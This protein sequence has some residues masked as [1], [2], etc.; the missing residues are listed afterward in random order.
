MNI[1]AKKRFGQNFLKDT[2]I[3]NQIVKSIPKN[4]YKLVEIGAGLGDLTQYLLKS[5]DVVAFEIDLDLCKYLKEKFATELK[6]GRLKLICGDVLDYWENS[7][8]LDEN[9][10]IVANLPYYV[11]T[12]IILKALDD[13]YNQSVTV[14]IQKEVADKFL[15]DIGDKEF[16]ALSVIAQSVSR[17]SFVVDAPPL[18]FTP[19]PKVD[20]KVIEFVKIDA[21]NISSEFKEFLGIAFKQPRKTLAK[22]LSNRYER[23]EINALFEDMDLNQ[24]IRPHQVETIDYH[25]IY[26][27]LEGSDIG[28]KERRVKTT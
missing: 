14:M 2:N 17:V 11:A 6:S 9:Y 13:R 1:K 23:E 3:V 4:S 28:R 20:S 26:T 8:L 12:K 19:P 16:S 24:S 25:Q 18:S 21:K 15:A 5:Q 7:S 27:I 22:N 10:K